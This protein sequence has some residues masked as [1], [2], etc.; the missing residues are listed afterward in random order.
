[1]HGIRVGNESPAPINMG[2]ASTTARRLGRG[3]LWR[4][5][6]MLLGRREQCEG[7]DGLLDAVRAAESRAIVLHG[8]PGRSIAYAAQAG[9][10]TT[11]AGFR[12]ATRLVRLADALGLPILTLIDTPGAAHD[13]AAEQ[14]GAGTAIGELMATAIANTESHARADRLAEEQAALRRVATMVAK[15]SPPAELLA[16][17][18]EELANVFGEVECLLFRDQGDGTASVVASCGAGMSAA[19]AVGTRLPTDGNSVAAT[20][21]REG[22][23]HRV[24]DYST[25]TGTIARRCHEQGAR[26]AVGCPIRVRGR[27]WG[28]IGAVR[29]RPEAFPPETETRMAEFADLV[30]TA[31]ANAAAR[32]EVQ[33]LAEEQA[34]LRRIAMLVAKGASATTVFDAVAAEMEGLLDADAVALC[35]YEGADE[36]TIVARRGLGAERMPPGTRVSDAGQNVTAIV[37]CSE[38]PARIENFDRARGA[39]AEHARS[40][41]FH[42]GVGAPIVVDGRLWGAIT[43]GWANEAPPPADTEQR[44]AQFAELLDTAIA[45]ADSREQ[46][47]ASRARLLTEADEARRRVVRDLHDGAQQRQV[48][49]II[50]LKLAQRAL[51]RKDEDPEAL[52]ADALEHAQQGIA[53]LRELAHGILPAA[54]THGGLATGVSTLVARLDLPVEVD[55]AAERL[56]VAIEAS[57]YFIVAEALTNVVKHAHAKHATITARVEDG[58]LRVQVRDDGIGGARRDGSGLLGLADRLAVLDGRLRIES[59]A[60]GGTLVA[61]DIPLAD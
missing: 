7:L 51:R 55:V 26:S 54:L 61:A 43:A 21:L 16:K 15:E 3:R 58:T 37:R 46:L 24:S 27:I 45:N 52:V 8:E 12:S 13:A 23:P 14:A 56:P 22:R 44:V 18:V 41:G 11:P 25:A 60:H 30:A 38:R 9:T 2:P 10:A 29:Y 40:F 53:E 17:V 28:V 57:A 4:C 20:V 34:A 6:E 1:M 48:N 19:F 32:A 33:R 39:L 47:T 49:T 31:I 35:R 5:V 59:P 42:G 36:I 50:T